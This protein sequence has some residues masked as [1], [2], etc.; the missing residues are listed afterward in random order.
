MNALLIIRD[1][2][3]ARTTEEK[4]ANP[5]KKSPT[6]LF[7]VF[8]T[9]IAVLSALIS[10]YT[11]YRLEKKLNFKNNAAT[12]ELKLIQLKQAEMNKMILAKIEG[13]QQAQ[14]QI[15]TEINSISNEIHNE[16][17]QKMYQNQDWLLLKARYYLELGQLNTHWSTDY[18]TTIALLQAAI[19]F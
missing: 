15:K 13:Q 1:L 6:T 18:Q 5:E 9:L 12:A 16:L 19:I 2:T 11:Y 3:M 17:K 7:V 14:E 8:I 4:K 10:A